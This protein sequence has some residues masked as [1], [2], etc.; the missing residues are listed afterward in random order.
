MIAFFALR[1]INT[2]SDF[3]DILSYFLWHPWLLCDSEKM[4]FSQ[5]WVNSV[6]RGWTSL[7]HI[8]RLDVWEFS[9]F[10]CIL[11]YILQTA[12]IIFIKV[13]VL[14]VLYAHALSKMMG[15]PDANSAVL[16]IW[17]V[18]WFHVMAWGETAH[19]YFGWVYSALACH[20]N[21]AWHRNLHTNNS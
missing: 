9:Q 2:F 18:V 20:V 21:R 8:L 17:S 1:C 7:L 5:W 11:N 15:I 3:Q 6:H 13:T 12:I 4:Q 16:I 19:I 14:S 10:S